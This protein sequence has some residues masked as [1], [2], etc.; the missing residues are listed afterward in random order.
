VLLF[1]AVITVLLL[2]PL[3]AGV[4]GPV[5]LVL[6]FL[7]AVVLRS[8]SSLINSLLVFNRMVKQYALLALVGTVVLG[9]V[10][11]LGTADETR[12]M[13]FG[14]TAMAVAPCVKIILVLSG[15]YAGKLKR[16]GC[17]D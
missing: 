1:L 17:V 14:M 11:Y 4:S 7:T 5:Y 15:L 12:I 10:T 16:C 8:F 2:L 9:G 3:L 6:V 13:F